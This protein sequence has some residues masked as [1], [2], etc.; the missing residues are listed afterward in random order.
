MHVLYFRWV[1]RV[2]L[3]CFAFRNSPILNDNVYE[4]VVYKVVKV[5]GASF[6]LFVMLTEIENAGFNCFEILTLFFKELLRMNN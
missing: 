3:L 2:S 6:L 4:R 1:Y 5:D